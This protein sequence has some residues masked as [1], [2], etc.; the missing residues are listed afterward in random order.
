MLLVDGRCQIQVDG[1]HLRIAPRHLRQ[2]LLQ[3]RPFQRFTLVEDLLERWLV[4]LDDAGPVGG[5][6]VL[7]PLQQLA[8]FRAGAQHGRIEPFEHVKAF[9]RQHQ[10]GDQAGADHV[11]QQVRARQLECRADLGDRPQ[12]AP[13]QG[14]GRRFWLAGIQCAFPWWHRRNYISGNN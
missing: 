6:R 13:P 14:Q 5:A 12:Q 4:D 1:Q 9:Q 3:A 11:V 2:Q 8:L 7:A 10:R